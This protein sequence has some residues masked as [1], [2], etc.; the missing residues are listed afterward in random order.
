MMTLS[1]CWIMRKSRVEWLDWAIGDSETGL[2]DEERQVLQYTRKGLSQTEI[3]KAMGFVQSEVSK[4]KTRAVQK[5][6][7]RLGKMIEE[8]TVTC[9]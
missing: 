3:S 1:A 4:R 9:V 6:R 8:G 2:T 5:L 7:D